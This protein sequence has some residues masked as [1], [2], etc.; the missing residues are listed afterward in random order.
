MYPSRATWAP[1]AGFAYSINDKTVLRGGFGLFY[2]RIQGNPT[3]YTLNNPPYVSSVSYNYGNLSDI[4]GAGA[5]SAPFGTLQTI[6]PNLKTPYS[7]QFSLSL[8]RTLPWS[9]FLE[10]DYVGTLGRHLLTEPDINQPSFA[11]L[12]AVPSTAN[13]NT[14][15]PYPGYSTIQQFISAATSNYHALQVQVS[16]RAGSILFTGAYTFSKALGNASSDTENDHDYFNLY[17]MYGPL[18]YDA[19]HVFSGSF[20]W[21][22]P[23]LSDKPVYLRAPFGSWQLSG[24]IHLQTGFPL[25][26]SGSTPILGTREA[27]YIGGSAL[28]PN[29]G[30]NGWI[31][32]AAYAPAA[33][34]S[35]GTAGA[36]DVRGPGLQQYDL[37]VAR[38]FPL[39]KEGTSL[40][41]RADFIN[42][43]NNV[44]FDSPDANVSDSAFGTISSAFPPRNIQLSLKLLF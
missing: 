12:A 34:A 33:Q 10:T 16:R 30:A 8:Q 35:F 11:V 26:I 38:F 19:T 15:R 31:N 9:L 22:L 44:N 1:R 39:W 2:D 17:A 27:N 42:A 14:L 40:Q 36:G 41:F 3:F 32:P 13:E 20:V 28:L 7:E 5:V 43:F 21:F 4:T 23:K 29:P 24:V 6:Q 18:S 37:S 25:N